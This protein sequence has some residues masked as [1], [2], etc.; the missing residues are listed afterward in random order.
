MSNE[1]SRFYVY[2]ANRVQ[3]IRVHG[4]SSQWRYVKTTSNTADEG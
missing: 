2:V 4:T 3:L 1:S